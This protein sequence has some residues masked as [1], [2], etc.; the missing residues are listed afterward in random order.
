MQENV[1]K[2]VAIVITLAC[3][4]YCANFCQIRTGDAS[5]NPA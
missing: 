4:A 2:K 3:Y 1:Q 5:V